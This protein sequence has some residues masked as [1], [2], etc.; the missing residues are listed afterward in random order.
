[1]PA[2]GTG[3]GL[4][5]AGQVDHQRVVGRCFDLV[6][7]LEGGERRDRLAAPVG[8]VGLEV[9]EAAVGVAVGGQGGADQGRIAVHAAAV[10]QAGVE[11]DE[12]VCGKC[13]GHATSVAAPP[14]AGL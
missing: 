4:E 14:G 10:D 5:P 12:A 3:D 13:V 6:Q 1:E 8:Q 2:V 7:H 11:H 9:A